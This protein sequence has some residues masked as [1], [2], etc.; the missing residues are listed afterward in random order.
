M[1][2]FAQKTS[3]PHKLTMTI[4]KIS[5]KKTSNI[6]VNAGIVGLSRFIEKY[7]IAFPEQFPSLQ[8]NLSKHKL[9]ISC[10]KL[11]DLLEDV[12]YFMGKEVYDTSSEKQILKADKYFFVKEPFEYRAFA[13]MN[14]FG[15]AGFVTKAPFGPQPVPRKQENVATF[16]KLIKEDKEFAEKIARIYREKGLLLKYFDITEEGLKPN[17]NSQ[18]GDSRIFLNEPYTKTPLID[19]SPEVLMPGENVCP[20]TNEK[21][22]KLLSSKGCLPFSS[23]L[24]N[25]NTFLISDDQKKISFKAKYLALFAS[26]ICFYSYQ[27]NFDSIIFHFFNSNNLQNIAKLY[28]GSMFRQKEELERINYQLNFRLTDFHIQRK[29]ADDF[30]IETTKDA[31]WESELAFMLIYTFYKSKFR[32]T[33]IDEKVQEKVSVDPFENNPLD[34][35]PITLVTFRADKFA[36]TLR[37]NFYEEYNNVKF[38]LRL[39][40]AL[41]SDGIPIQSIWQGLKLNSP[42]AAKMKQN[43]KTWNRGNAVERQI[44]AKVLADVFKG[45][46]IV[47]KIEKFFFDSYKYLLAKENTGYR[48]YSK[49]LKFLIIYENSI[50]FGNQISMN[51][52]LQQRAI[53][54][55]RSLSHG[56]INFDHPKDENARKGNAKNGRKYIIRLHKAR[57][58]EQFTEALISIM[59]KYGVSVSN[60]LLENISKDNFIMIRQY[61]VIGA[62][63]G[64]NSIL[65]SSSNNN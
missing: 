23:N 44:R 29:G 35:T 14:S 11:L 58:L 30:K 32:E 8:F 59:K 25:F 7:K 4:T 24:E 45:K 15:L 63:N 60:E 20:I 38:I 47:N 3:N 51:E 42:K 43:K 17:E 22:E 65:S 48:N 19:F 9:E 26:S 5:F 54:M 2:F 64:I 55:G 33:I 28:D 34:K 61:A 57:T 13:K 16:Q 37:P 41:E 36:S 40:Y 50:N 56:I 62:L 1:I 27:N 49:L 46:T 39:I 10:N 31:V 53:K 21:F 12:Y 6:F 52:N 18:K